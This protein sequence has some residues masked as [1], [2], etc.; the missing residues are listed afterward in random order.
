MTKQTYK[1]VMGFDF[2]TR[3]IGIA[4]GQAIT[5]TAN[6]I[7]SIKARDGI[8][9]WDQLGRIIEEWQPDAFV[10]GM[11][12]NMDGTESEMS[13]RAKKFGN[14]LKGRF[15]KPWHPVDER[16]T[17]F[18]AKEWAGKLGHKGHYGSNP[19]DDLAAQLILESWMNGEGAE[20]LGVGD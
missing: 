1:T 11:P 3:N 5:C 9:D 4:V 18:E 7:P 15:N 8:P 20:H 10:V 19:I 14:R 2:G 17:S 6:A 12:L 13:R 16:L